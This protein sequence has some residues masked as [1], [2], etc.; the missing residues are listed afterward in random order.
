MR[1]VWAVAALL[2]FLFVLPTRLTLLMDAPPAAAAVTPQWTVV[3][4]TIE[5]NA[6][7]GKLLTRVSPAEMQRLVEHTRPVYDLARLSVGHPF[8]LALDTDGLVRAFSYGIDELR[9]LR[10]VRRGEAFQA[11]VESRSYEVRVGGAQGEI[12]SSLFAAVTEAGEDDQL[13]L[14]LADIFAWD[15]DFNTE[16]QRGDAFRVAVEK[17]HLDGRF[18]K[19]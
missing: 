9:T 18:A 2:V 7:L 1:R 4:G 6:T 3:Q 8:G 15:V 5:R 19:Y 11:E 16:L 13:A 17:L 14:D 12:R 10:V